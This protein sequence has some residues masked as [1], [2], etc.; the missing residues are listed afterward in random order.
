MRHAV[1]A[2]L[3]VA[4]LLLG[5]GCAS[6]QKTAAAQN[7]QVRLGMAEQMAARND[8]AGAFQI[9]DGLVREDPSN[10]QALLLRGKALRKQE[11]TAEAEADLRRLVALEP[12]YSEA[13]AELAILLERQGRTAEALEHHEE[14][15]KIMPGQPRYLNNLG[16]ALLVRGRAKDAVPKLEEALRAEP[17]S[18][19]LRNNLGF[20][21]AATGDFTRAFEQFRLGG[22]PVQARNNLGFA[23]ERA[24][25][26]TQAY[27]MYL[28]AAR[29]DPKDAT[30]R[31]NLTHVA[32]R[33]GRPVPP[34]AATIRTDSEIG[35]S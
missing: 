22:T 27:D 26:L 6:K 15:V 31:S 17:Q 35:G 32:T 34:E 2:A 20:A 25:N 24:G 18:P 30:C 16:F 7:R 11:M 23:Y 4:L 9:A 8:W 33:L 19:R 12:Y 1:H 29:L 21:Y 5:S 28:Q 14:A 10:A 13:H 3:A